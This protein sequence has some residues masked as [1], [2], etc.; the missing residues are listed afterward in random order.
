MSIVLDSGG[1]TALTGNIAKLRELRRRGLWPPL[2]PTAV[3]TEC[4]TGDHR[5]DFHV[6]RFV[7]RC[8]ISP[9]TEL[10]A[11][12][13]AALRTRCGREVSAVDAIVVATADH[14]GG[15]VVLTSDLKDLSALACN[16]V[17]AVLVAP[18]D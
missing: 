7:S 4:L 6:N 10:I 3:L 8:M 15:A 5:Y 2:V 18:S 11:R 13:A 9:L 17:N 14:V 1:V 12:D 16:T